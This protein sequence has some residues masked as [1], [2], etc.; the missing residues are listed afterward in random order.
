MTTEEKDTVLRRK[1]ASERESGRNGQ[2]ALLRAM[3][4]AIAM[5]GTERMEL[6]IA[7]IGWRQTRKTA[8]ELEALMPSDGLLILLEGTAERFAAFTL[9]RSIVEALIQKQTVGEVFGGP[10]GDRMF[11]STDAALIEPVVESFLDHSRAL[12]DVNIDQQC[13]RGFR[14][15]QHVPDARSLGLSLQASEYR[16]FSLQ[17]DLAGGEVQ[18]DMQVM[19]P[20]DPMPQSLPVEEDEP[21]QDTL[22]KSVSSAR[23]EMTT[24][25][26][27]VHMTLDALHRIEPGQVLDLSDASLARIDLVAQDGQE[28]AQGCLGRLD[29]MR[30]VRL[31]LG[32]ATPALGAPDMDLCLPGMGGFDAPEPGGFGLDTPEIG[33]PEIGQPD[34]DL[35]DIGLP[36]LSMDAG[37]GSAAPGLSV[38][39]LDEL[40]DLPDLPGL[41]DD[42]PALDDDD[43]DGQDLVPLG[44]LDDLPELP[45]LDIKGDA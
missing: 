5:A 26:G 12:T 19:L 44:G 33:L 25:L 1:T 14:F 29:G 32:P 16:V 4:L 34:M 45:P 9:S 24:V 42:L 18:G 35:P 20:D 41:G 17:L 38:D 22:A 37:D 36:A 23:V 40:P 28:V 27:Q 8:E 6:P 2:R 15:S 21:A 31:A 11:T 13:L 43:G 10:P 7:A 30:A 3:R 39:A